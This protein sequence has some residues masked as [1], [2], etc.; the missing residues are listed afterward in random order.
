MNIKVLNWSFEKEN[1]SQLNPDWPAVKERL[2]I[3]RPGKGSIELC[4]H[5]SDGQLMRLVV[6]FE[7][8]WFLMTLGFETVLKWAAHLCQYGPDH[9]LVKKILSDVIRTNYICRDPVIVRTTFRQFYKTGTVP[10]DLIR[11]GRI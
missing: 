1:G 11:R 3:L 10:V 6:R 2:K 7:D 4:G 8:G 9:F 5:S